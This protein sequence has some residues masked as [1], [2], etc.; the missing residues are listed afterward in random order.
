M[1]KDRIMT[2]PDLC[3]SSGAFGRENKQTITI[4]ESGSYSG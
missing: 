4:K 1:W 2:P 3:M